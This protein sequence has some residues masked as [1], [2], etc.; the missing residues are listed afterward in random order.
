MRSVKPR[1]ALN[2]L[3]LHY[4]FSGTGRY[5]AQLVA[6]IERWAEPVL[7]GSRAFPPAVS[8][9]SHDVNVVPK[10]SVQ[11][12]ASP[13]D[14]LPRSLAKIWYE[15]LGLPSA[16]SLAKVDLVHYPYFAAPLWPRQPTIVTVHDLVP[17]VRPEYR[18]TAGQR[19]YTTLVSHSLHF[20]N[21]IITDSQASAHDLQRLLGIPAHQIRVIPLAVDARFRPLAT[22]EEE[23]WADTVLARYG[24]DR[25]YLLYLGG[26]DRRKNVDCLIKA[27]AMLR[28]GRDLPHCLVIVGAVRAGQPL[29]YDPRP[30]VERLGIAETVRFL[31]VV[32]DDDVRALYGRADTFVFPSLYE[33]F[34]LP[35]LEAMACGAPVVCSCASSL[36]E[37][38]GEAGLLFDPNDPLALAEML[39]RVLTDQELRQDLKRRGPKQ[40]AAF[41]WEATLA[42]TAQVYQEVTEQV[43]G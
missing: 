27:F 8:V 4:P 3:F 20:A 30:D 15:Q 16:A 42:A 9:F 2:A 11:L 22:P 24:L 13:I 21:R 17:I 40:A 29:F 10:Q 26:L 34:G 1:V 28:R 7:L 41:T 37:V 18:R 36:P 14:R 39:R 6:A 32:G 35:P 12:L 23:V 25:P 38:V 19:L 5:V 31:G 43:V 33:G